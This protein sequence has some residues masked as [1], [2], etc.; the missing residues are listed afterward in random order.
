M[1]SELR[2]KY[3]LRKFLFIKP[4]KQYFALINQNE[5]WSSVSYKK[6]FDSIN[7]SHSKWILIPN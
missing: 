7:N 2:D 5:F 4:P 3:S 6:G 1:K